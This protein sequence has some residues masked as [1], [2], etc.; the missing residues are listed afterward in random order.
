MPRKVIRQS[1]CDTPA[2]CCKLFQKLFDEIAESDEYNAKVEESN[3]KVDRANL[4][5]DKENK[6]A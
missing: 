3:R 5:V 4:K 6:D 1:D 2:E